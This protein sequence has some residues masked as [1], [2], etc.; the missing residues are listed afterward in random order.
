MDTVLQATL[1]QGKLAEVSEVGVKVVF[2]GRL[3][4]L[5]VPLRCV[6]SDKKLEVN[7][8]VELYLSYVRVLTK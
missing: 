6:I 5:N 7:D 4:T 3:G 1:V 2:N 8:G